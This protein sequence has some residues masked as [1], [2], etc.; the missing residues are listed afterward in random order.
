[1]K[2]IFCYAICA[3]LFALTL[4]AGEDIV[5]RLALLSAAFCFWR[6]GSKLH[7]GAGL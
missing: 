6:T 1:M 4:L 7:K 3:A 2:V 5:L